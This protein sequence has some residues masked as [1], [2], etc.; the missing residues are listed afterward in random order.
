M[1]S[2]YHLDT[3]FIICGCNKCLI[4]ALC[5]FDVL[6]K[7]WEKAPKLFLGESALDGAFS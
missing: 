2:D 5:Y 7:S 1:M 6:N 3:F 4:C